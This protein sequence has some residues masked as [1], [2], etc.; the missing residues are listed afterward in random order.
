MRVIYLCAA[1][2]YH[3]PPLVRHQSVP[4]CRNV[5]RTTERARGETRDRY[6][7]VINIHVFRNKK[8]KKNKKNNKTR[9]GLLNA[10][11][12]IVPTT[13]GRTEASKVD[14]ETIKRKRRSTVRNG[15]NETRG[16]P[17]FA[18]RDRLFKQPDRFAR[19]FD[20]YAISGTPNTEWQ[21]AYR[22][23]GI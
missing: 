7:T 15:P 22:V 14:D 23:V 6:S 17:I 9:P 19:G 4:F 10:R 21:S 8:T 12:R 3:R 2:V 20:A 16:K 13:R 11:E 1:R 5:L 18:R